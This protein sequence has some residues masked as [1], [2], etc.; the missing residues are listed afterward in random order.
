RALVPL[1]GAIGQPG[2][3]EIVASSAGV[4]Y[5]ATS[6]KAEAELGFSPRSIEDGLRALLGAAEPAHG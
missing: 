2:L 4:T 3:A 5:W 6:A 1:G